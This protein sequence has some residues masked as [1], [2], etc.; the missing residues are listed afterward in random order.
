MNVSWRQRLN[1][2]RWAIKYPRLTISFWLGVAFAGLLAFSSLKYALFPDVTFPVVIIKAEANLEDVIATETELTNPLEKP[3]LAIDNI[4]DI[5]SSTFA[6][7][8]VI[9]ILFF[10]G[11]SLTEATNKVKQAIAPVSLP[12]NTKV[13][14]IP[15]NLNESIAISYVL[16]SDTLSLTEITK[17]AETKIIPS[18]NSI[19][20]I[21]QVN[22]LGVTNIPESTAN[23]SLSRMM[24]SLVR[25]D[26]DDAVAIQ[27]V[28]KGEANTLDVV[29]LVETQIKQL[30]PQLTDIKIN[31]AQT[32]ANYIKE[33]TKSTI[34]ALILAIILAVFVI[35]PFLGSFRSTFITAIAIPLSL[36]GTCMVMAGANFNLET[37]TLLALAL[38]IGIVVDDAIVDVENI[39][40]HL[41][42]GDTPKQAAIK[43]TDE[44]GLTVSA[45]SLTI[46]AVF[47]PVALMRGNLGQFFQPFGLTVSAAVII[48]LLVAR[49]LSPVL[50]MY[51]LQKGKGQTPL[52]PLERGN[53]LGKGIM[54]LLSSISSFYPEWLT[55]WG[56]LFIAKY[57]KVLQWSLAHRW[58]VVSFALLSFI[59]GIALI[60]LIPQGFIPQ[61]DRG[62]FNIIYTSDLPQIPQDWNLKQNNQ[63][64]ENQEKV[65]L[66]KGDLG[67]S[68]TSQTTSGGENEV[69]VPLY[70]GDLGGSNI[71]QTNDSKGDLGGLTTNQE[72]NSN[73]NWL[74]N[75]K[76]NPN[77][78]LLR[79]TR[80]IG[81]KIEA[82]VL[83]SPAV[84][85]AFTIVGFRG[86][87]NK[88]KI[89]VKLKDKR[90]STTMK[91]QQQIRDSLPDI[92]G[93]DISVE[94]IK[95]VD[96]GD[97]KPFSLTL[98]SDN[99]TSL[100]STADKVKSA[101]KQLPAL[102]DLSTSATAT[103]V[104][105][106][107]NL[108][109]IDHQNNQRAV[110]IS[111][112]LTQGQGLGD[113][114]QQVVN[115]INPLLPPEVKL[116]L[117][118]D[119]ARMEDVINQFSFSFGLSVALML[120]VLLGLFGS[121]LE[122][123]VVG[124]ALP[125]SIIGAML[126]LLIT[127]SELGMISL[128][129]VVFLLGLLDKNALLLV[130]Y[131]NQL[132]RQGMERNDAILT[133]GSVRLRPILMTTF[134][135]ILGM[136]PLAIGWGAGAEL[137]QPMAIAIIGGL[138][139]SS[140]LSLIFVPV[141]YSLIEDWWDKFKSKFSD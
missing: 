76:E 63:N 64:Q 113:V 16:T 128:I 7:Q 47:L 116:N 81:K 34:D 2:S 31:L 29:N 38:V 52:I 69:K 97:G 51:W 85:S 15:Y 1:I 43:G 62:E 91:I 77:G 41:E 133:T 20:G 65:P 94:D 101:L 42:K 96:T 104:E 125:L 92:K 137:R 93:A 80:R 11:D 130:D 5:Y 67:K 109:S 102:T 118:G 46:V 119:S 4:E 17:V 120:L 114:S 87:P 83:E 139:T 136:L 14:V 59:I 111:A 110:T 23:D 10:A 13:E 112:N 33:A 107:T 61:L 60:P 122:P 45:S 141:S 123:L 30:Q 132:Q 74:S 78:F 68:N 53:S 35:Y 131:A 90:E 57:R 49:T 27:V 37:I 39:K 71:S 127:R 95:F 124:L 134:S 24:P 8:S 115:I 73:F 135:T 25:W 12:N 55:N 100:Y 3:L 140:L 88:G 72:K 98:L 103:T 18:L 66:A 50:A 106:E 44:I 9:N 82:V 89:Y 79:R 19:E 32:E 40:R 108:F 126:A 48:S 117:G 54:S 26:G 6:G 22:V 99:L 75:L 56:N 70:K 121:F 36:L 105:D 21:L 129:G 138:I 84:E 58:L 86:Q 28:K